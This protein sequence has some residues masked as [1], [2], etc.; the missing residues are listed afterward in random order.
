MKKIL[1][2]ILS[3]FISVSPLNALSVQANIIRSGILQTNEVWSGTVEVK[4]DITIPK[5]KELLIKPG[6]SLIYDQ[7]NMPEIKVYG[8]LKVGDKL[9]ND[10]QYELLPAGGK[11]QIIQITPYEVDTKILRDEFNAFRIQYAIIWTLLGGGLIYA[12]SHR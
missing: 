7:H 12:V 9:L 4:G 11:T 3:L 5:D 10:S 8:T 6:T 1:V 2:F